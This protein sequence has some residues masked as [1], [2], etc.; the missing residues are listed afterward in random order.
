M[1]IRAT[2][3][4][5]LED[6]ALALLVGKRRG[7]FQRVLHRFPDLYTRLPIFYHLWQ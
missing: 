7:V 1:I 3:A 5:G 4:P 2:T 6:V